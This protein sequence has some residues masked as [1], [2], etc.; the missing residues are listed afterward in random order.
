MESRL[1]G[2]MDYITRSDAS[3]AYA[4][5][6]HQSQS[7][8]TLE[9]ADNGKPIN[10]VPPTAAKNLDFPTIHFQT[11]RRHSC[12]G[13]CPCSCHKTRRLGTPDVLERILGKLFLGYVGLP[14]IFHS[15]TVLGCR[16]NSSKSA[17][18]IYRFPYWFWQRA[19]NVT[20]SYTY[21]TGPELLLRF[22][23]VRPAHCD[24]FICARMGDAEGLQRLLDNRQ[25]G[26]TLRCSHAFD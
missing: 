18:M 19:V 6:R 3:N 24:W 9:L 20:F 11:L 16:Q 2:L 8:T 22:P 14:S 23:C 10:A 1:D 5:A 21:T 12:D 15:C 13:N 7:Q 26:R 25:A 17:K 4:F